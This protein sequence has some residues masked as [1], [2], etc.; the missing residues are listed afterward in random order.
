MTSTKELKESIDKLQQSMSRLATAISVKTEY[1]NK[2][3]DY[4]TRQNERMLK[5][6]IGGGLA[7]FLITSSMYMILRIINGG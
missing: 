3:F 1:D 5:W 2:V 7:T 4:I 6:I